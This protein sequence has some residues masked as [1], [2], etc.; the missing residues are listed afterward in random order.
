MDKSLGSY[1]PSPKH[2]NGTLSS[3][4]L[5]L[6]YGRRK[7]LSGYLKLP[8]EWL[9]LYFYVAQHFRV[10]RAA[11]TWEEDTGLKTHIPRQMWGIQHS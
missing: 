4:L 9:L 3:E 11:T 10:W 1:N 5:P 8:T 6:S 7:Q 2:S